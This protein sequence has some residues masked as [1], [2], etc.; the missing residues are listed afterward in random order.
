ML[1]C[2]GALI[3]AGER[4]AQSLALPG[5]K[6]APPIR[7]LPPSAFPEL[8]PAVRKQLEIRHCMIP[9]AD[10]EEKGKT[11]VLRGRFFASTGLDWAVLCSRDGASSI[12]VLRESGGA[13]PSEFA[14]SEDDMYLQTVAADKIAYSRSGY[15][16]PRTSGIINGTGWRILIFRRF[17]MM[18]WTTASREKGIKFYYFRKT[19]FR[20]VGMGD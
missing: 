18:L 9:Q 19:G 8:P 12:L 17:I 3:C 4:N 2:A 5:P 10:F 11:N 15:L 6:D 16:R 20:V 14:S 13:R 7:R 1:F